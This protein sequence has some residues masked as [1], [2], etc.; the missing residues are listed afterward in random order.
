MATPLVRIPQPQGGTMYAFASAA[1]D[2]TRAFNNADLKFEFSRF[3]LLD[4][5]DFTTSVNNSNTFDFTRLKDTS[6]ANYTPSV[7]GPNVDFSQTFQN[8]VL[9]SEELL[10]QDD[11]FDPVILS[12]DAEKLF[13]KWLSAVGAIRFT[14]ADSMQSNVG[15]YTESP[16]SAQIGQVYSRVV[17]YLGTIDA[18]NDIAYKGNAY[19]EVYINVP[20]S[21]G[22]TPVV[23]FEPRNFNTTSNRIYADPQWIEG[24]DNQTHPDPNLNLSPVVDAYSAQN[25]A[26]YDIDTN[27]TNSVCIDWDEQSYYGITDDSTVKNMNDYA[28]RGQDFRFNAILVYYDLYSASIPAQRS[29]NL[30]GI[31]ILDDIKTQ[32]GIGSKINEQIKYK[33]NEITGLNGNAFSLKLNIKFNTSLDNVGVETNVNDF[34]TFSM[35]LFMDTTTL[36]ENA[37]EL[38]IEAN[39]RYYNITQRLDD[40]ENLVLASESAED[41]EN[42][43][44]KLEDDFQNTS[45]QLQDSDSLLKLITKTNDKINSLINGTI[46]VEL[47]YNTDVLFNGIGTSIDKSVPNKIKVN[48]VVKGY[49]NLKLFIWDISTSTIAGN[50]DNLNQLDIQSSGSGLSQY[51]VWCKLKP[52]TNRISLINKFSTNIAN[53]DLNIY[54]DDSNVSWKEGQIIKITFETINING[55]N[56]KIH[57]GS[58]TGFNQLIADIIP[59]QLLSNKPYIELVCVNPIVYQFEVD[60]IR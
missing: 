3:A 49:E 33:P 51:G 17:K 44:K 35:D 45:V 31:L 22:N 16:D 41:L 18:E 58:S 46:P 48:S 29:T 11:D 36:L 43:I 30:Y 32:G 7:V 26:Y 38:L 59:A 42:R 25:G 56:I 37:A 23:L 14:A 2:I 40:I 52:F 9:N 28:K 19:H 20:S 12:S 50:L 15:N 4:L 5:P 39:E 8:Y 53:D 24:R 55:N 1:R 60:I 57:T 34:T 13:F 27:G 6:G 10:L 54:I 21:V 47:Q